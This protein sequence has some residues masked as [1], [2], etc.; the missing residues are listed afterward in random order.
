M[1]H[2]TG[3][4]NYTAALVSKNRIPVHKESLRPEAQ[5]ARGSEQETRL[6]VIEFKNDH[7]M[8]VD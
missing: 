6:R 4:D 8:D 7:V 5:K 1:V 2:N 3:E